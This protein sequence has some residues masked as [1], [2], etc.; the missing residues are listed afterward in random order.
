[1][2]PYDDA[3]TG[4]SICMWDIILG[5]WYSEYLPEPELP[6]NLASCGKIAKMTIWTSQIYNAKIYNWGSSDDGIFHLWYDHFEYYYA[7]IR[8]GRNY[9][10]VKL[11]PQ[12]KKY[13]V[14][15]PES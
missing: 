4:T 12:S 15:L 6:A 11:I 8:F 10:R 14:F 5:S 1:M 7:R 13:W 9:F 3:S 2:Y